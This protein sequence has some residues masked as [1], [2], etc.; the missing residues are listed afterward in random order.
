MPGVYN[1]K[2]MS[3]CMVL[4]PI[5]N[6][7]YCTNTLNNEKSQCDQF[8]YVW[9]TQGWPTTANY[10]GIIGLA[11]DGHIIVGPYNSNGELWHCDEHDFCNGS[12]LKDGTYAYVLTANFP[13]VVG[14]W[15]PATIQYKKI[16]TCSLRSCGAMAGL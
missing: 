1:F 7:Q 5:Y 13:Y 8:P 14:C 6:P 2:T 11:R 16:T 9:M 15:G 4:P 12:F 10:G 3:P